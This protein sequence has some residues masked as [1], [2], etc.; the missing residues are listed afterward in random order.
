MLPKE[1]IYM[2]PMSIKVIDH[3]NFGRKP[4]VGIYNITDLLKY[5][6]DR[7]KEECLVSTIGSKELFTN[8]FIKFSVSYSF[9]LYFKVFKMTN[10]Q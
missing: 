10:L 7:T 3:R 1:E 9:I 4:I 6:V 2:P 8:I 5:V